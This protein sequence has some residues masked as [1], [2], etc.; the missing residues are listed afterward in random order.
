M[1]FTVQ[2]DVFTDNNY[3]VLNLMITNPNKNNW[4]QYDQSPLKNITITNNSQLI[5][6]IFDYNIIE[7]IEN[8]FNYISSFYNSEVSFLIF[9]K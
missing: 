4:L 8:D 5:E 6:E 2:S 9:K 7:N 1:S 3:F